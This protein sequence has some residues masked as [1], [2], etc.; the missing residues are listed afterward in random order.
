MSRNFV[1]TVTGPDRVGIVDDVTGVVLN[2]GGNVETSRMTRLGGEF[3]VMMLVTIPE[4]KAEGLEADFGPLVDQGYR[5]AVVPARAE[6]DHGAAGWDPYHIEIDGA[7]HEG[8]IHEVAHHLA[9]HGISIEEMDSESAPASTSGVPLF[10]MRALV[11]APPDADDAWAEGLR[12]IGWRLNLEVD[13]AP[14]TDADDDDDDD[15]G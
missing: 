6:P 4:D 13:V 11:L 9:A 3:A 2:R 10:S 8:I 1:L 14:V 12:E 7:D 5:A 15:E